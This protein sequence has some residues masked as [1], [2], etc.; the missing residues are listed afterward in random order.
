MDHLAELKEFAR[1][2][3]RGQGIGDR[4]V[5]AVLPRITNDEPGHPA[6]WARVWTGEADRLAFAGRPL[7]ACRHYALA[8]FPYHGDD[9]RRRAQDNCVRTFDD[10]RRR[11]GV[12][13]LVLD[14]PDGTV[15]CW[16]SGLDARRRRPLLV[17]MGG[18]VSV[19]EQWAPLLP[20]LARLGYAA[21]VTEMPGV[22]EN[23]LRYHAD[24]WRLLPFLMDRLAGRAAVTRTSVLGLS[25]SGHLAL[26][27]AAA[28]PRIRSVHTVGAPVAGFFT[29]PVW[30]PRVPGI[31]V[32]TLRR[33]TGAA[34]DAEL[35]ALLAD[36]PLGPDVLGAVGIPVGYVVSARDEIIPPT[37]HRLLA[38]ALPRVRLKEFDDVHGSPA[39]LGALRKW[40]ITS[41]LR[42]RVT[43][44]DRRATPDRRPPTRANGTGAGGPAHGS[45]APAR[46][47]TA[48]GAPFAASATGTTSPAAP[49]PS[50]YADAV[51]RQPQPTPAE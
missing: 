31:T 44:R 9:V 27:A 15:V 26:R 43:T 32:A 48:A 39:H 34:S 7:D 20:R 2:H 1:L 18:I 14:H 46:P 25:F 42:A 13:R 50:G 21:V 47:G 3:A 16:A 28:D 38:S 30:W 41:L 22:G 8:R 5:A 35:R 33:L 45:D 40:L 4:Q 17:V 6:S 19:K 23:T 29:D 12:E 24:S 11:R 51:L 10:W 37:E 36:F 49:G